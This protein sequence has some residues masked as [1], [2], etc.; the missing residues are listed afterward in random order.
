MPRYGLNT[1]DVVVCARSDQE[2]PHGFD[3]VGRTV[4]SVVRR[5]AAVT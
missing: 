1:D 3:R 4:V 2:T 5:G